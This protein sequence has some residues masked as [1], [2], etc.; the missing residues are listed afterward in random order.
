MVKCSIH[1][2]DI[3]ARIQFDILHRKDVVILI[4]KAFL[5]DSQ[6]IARLSSQLGY[7]VDVSQLEERLKYISNHNDHIVYVMKSNHVLFGWIHAH[8]RF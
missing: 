4:R 6:E 7:P 5:R 3:Y 2:L 8:V 1:L